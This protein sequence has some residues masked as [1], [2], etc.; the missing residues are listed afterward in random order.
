LYIL[1]AKKGGTYAKRRNRFEKGQIRKYSFST[2]SHPRLR[3]T[4]RNQT[5]AEPNVLISILKA[6]KPI[7]EDEYA[8][9]QETD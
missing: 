1:K 7:D 5:L 8:D 3:H 9:S 4:S 2:S 6:A